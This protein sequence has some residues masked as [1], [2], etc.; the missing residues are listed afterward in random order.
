M[1]RTMEQSQDSFK[2]DG[3]YIAEV[4]D[5]ADPKKRDRVRV[6]VHGIMDSTA[7]ESCPWAEQCGAIF[8]GGLN[9]VGFSTA[10]KVGSLVYVMFLYGDVSIPVYYG[11]VRGGSD[12]SGYHTLDGIPA[13]DILGPE[14]TALDSAVQYPYNNVIHTNAGV[15]IM[16]DTPGN[17][18]IAIKH[19]SGSY[20]E[21]KPDGTIV[22]KSVV[23]SFDVLVG[24]KSVYVGGKLDEEIKGD[25]E[26]RI[27]GKN[28]L[29]VDGAYI[30]SASTISLN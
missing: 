11:Y 24:D 4:V 18:R 21:I 9:Q 30:L 29:S 13:G 17:E 25:L 5:N 26:S 12:G 27:G 10:P 1:K 14:P 3:M 7:A 22:C 20:I 23:D 2:L 8:A 15:I 28:Q 19:K 6:R 16:D